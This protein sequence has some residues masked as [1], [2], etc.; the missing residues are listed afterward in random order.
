M[1]NCTFIQC[2]LCVAR[3]TRYATNLQIRKMNCTLSLALKF[4]PIKLNYNLQQKDPF[5]MLISEYTWVRYSA[6]IQRHTVFQ[7][8]QGETIGCI[9]IV[10]LFLVEQDWKCYSNNT[11]KSSRRVL[12][13]ESLLKGFMHLAIHDLESR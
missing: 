9:G 8:I 1:M 10:V 6:I 13:T 2:V 5:D 7:A 12:C 4:P 3:T 11:N